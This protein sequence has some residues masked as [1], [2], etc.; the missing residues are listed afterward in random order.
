M[1]GLKLNQPN[2]RGPSWGPYQLFLVQT[3]QDTRQQNGQVLYNENNHTGQW[4]LT[5]YDL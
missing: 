2:E 1:L 3:D 4:A 5:L